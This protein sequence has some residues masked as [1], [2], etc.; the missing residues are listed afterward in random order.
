M[1]PIEEC[2]ERKAMVE[3]RAARH[4]NVALLVLKAGDSSTDTN[5]HVNVLQLRC[6]KNQRAP[7]LGDTYLLP[8]R[9]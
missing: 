4:V 1:R 9:T 8:T 2:G 7:V 3:M 5:P 6:A